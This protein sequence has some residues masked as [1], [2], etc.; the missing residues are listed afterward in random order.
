MKKQE[1][2][3]MFKKIAVI[4]CAV[5]LIVAATVSGTIAWLTAETEAIT[6][7]FTVG[8]INITLNET[9]GTETDGK[10][11]FSFVPGD[12]I[13]K[14]PKV[15][16]VQGSE[17]CYLFIK[18][19]ENNNIDVTK[20]QG[21]EKAL[22]YSIA[23]GWTQYG[24]TTNGVSYYYR[25]VNKED[26]TRQFSIIK[27]DNVVVSN[28]ITKSDATILTTTKPT[29]TFTAAAIQT[30]NITDANE[31]S[32]VIDDAFDKLPSSFKN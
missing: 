7:T 20:D 10:R 28:Y 30:A 1:R 16:V 14:D 6:N 19:T 13:A 24:T 22:I 4:F 15:S 26:N 8:N 11:N 12:T 31:D 2:N 23:D 17:S 3:A 9:K 32:S 5:V 21:T 18:V 27:D 29:L 25:T